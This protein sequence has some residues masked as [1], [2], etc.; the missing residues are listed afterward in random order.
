[1]ENAAESFGN[2]IG[3][4]GRPQMES[5]LLTSSAMIALFGAVFHGRV[6]GRRYMHQVYESK[7]GVM[8]ASRLIID[9][10][11]QEL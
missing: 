3:F 10:S 6:G 11:M 8:A 9:C 2:F 4:F 5:L 1:M 7:L